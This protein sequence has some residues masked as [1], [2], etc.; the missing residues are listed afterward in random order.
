MLLSLY[1]QYPISVTSLRN[2]VHTYFT[3]IT[4]TFYLHTLTWSQLQ[5]I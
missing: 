2:N 1:T 4:F 5:V 3:E